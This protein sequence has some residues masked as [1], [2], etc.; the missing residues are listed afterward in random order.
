MC[1]ISGIWNKKEKLEERHLIR[2]NDRLE[3]RGPD[4]FGTQ[5]FDEHLGLAHRRLSILDVSESGAQPMK[6]ISGR[7]YITYN[8]EV[9][10]FLELREELEKKGHRFISESDTEVILSAFV[11]WGVDAFHR[12]NGMWALAIWDNISKELILSRDRFGIKPLYY[13]D[14]SSLFAFASETNAFTSLHGFERRPHPQRLQIC[15]ED[16]Y[17]LEGRGYTIYDGIYQLLPGHYIRLKEGESPRQKRWYHIENSSS[18]IPSDYGDQVLK[19]K[20][21]FL[22]SCKLRMRSDVPIATALSGGVDSTAVYS[23]VHHLMK[24]KDAR[25]VPQDWQRAFVA[26]FPETSQDETEYA[27]S[28]VAHTG[29]KAVYLDPRQGN[30]VE[31]LI[32]TTRHFDGISGTPILALMTVYKGMNENGVKVSLD[33]HGVD[34]MLYGY[35]NMVYAALNHHKWHGSKKDSVSVAAVLSQLYDPDQAESKLIEFTRD[36]ENAFKIRSGFKAKIKK[37]I[38]KARPEPI[39][40]KASDFLVSLSDKPYDFSDKNAFDRMVYN[41]FFLDTLP[42]LLRNFDKAAM[43]NGVEIRMP[44]MDYQ[45]VEYAFGLPFQSKIGNGFTK[46]I[47]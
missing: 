20:D 34:E 16:T 10:N 30:L 38:R 29:G 17:A 44:F 13:L 7:Y 18:S 11:E 45:L 15:I 2:F 40:I 35:R 32:R 21:V 23:M 6:D 19:F 31:D 36:I 1:G 33:G 5:L 8:G 37:M 12:F 41:E 4:G 14:T 47:L 28:A 24:S 42:S 46:R 43:M 25:R 39:E 26:V 27:E 3:H 22:T 9:F